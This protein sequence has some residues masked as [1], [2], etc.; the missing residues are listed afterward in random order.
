MKNKEVRKIQFAGWTKRNF[1]EIRNKLDDLEIERPRRHKKKNKCK[2]DFIL[3]KHFI[4]SF[5]YCE[6]KKFKC[7]KCGKHKYGD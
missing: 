7:E 6:F 5:D 3:V 2:H 1:K 4:S